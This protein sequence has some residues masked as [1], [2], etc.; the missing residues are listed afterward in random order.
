VDVRLE[1]WQLQVVG[2]PTMIGDGTPSTS[3]S[4]R[5]SPNR[6]QLVTLAS[7][8]GTDDVMTVV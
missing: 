7:I 4:T 5:S 3:T 8:Y 1:L 2:R 6:A